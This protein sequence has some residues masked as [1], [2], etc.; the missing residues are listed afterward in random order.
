[1]MRNTV[2]PRSHRLSWMETHT[3]DSDPSL[4]HTQCL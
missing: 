1:M 3:E 4:G 2:S